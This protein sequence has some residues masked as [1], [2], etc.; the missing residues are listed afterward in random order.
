MLSLFL[1]IVLFLDIALYSLIVVFICSTVAIF[2]QQHKD[3]MYQNMYFQEREKWEQLY[4]SYSELYKSHTK[5]QKEYDKL[6]ENEKKDT[7]N[8]SGV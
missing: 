3:R 2:V 7:N 6:L 8:N 5:L 4:Y 1:D